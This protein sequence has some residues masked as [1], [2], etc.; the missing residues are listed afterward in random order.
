MSSTDKDPTHRTISIKVDNYTATL[1]ALTL[2][3]ALGIAAIL[4]GCPRPEQPKPEPDTTEASD[5]DG[6]G[7]DEAATV[8]ES[9]D[10]APA[11]RPDP[12]I[13]QGQLWGP[14]FPDASC[15]QPAGLTLT[16]AATIDEDGVTGAI[17]APM[18][19][20]SITCADPFLTFGQPET[21]EVI[22]QR[23]HCMIKSPCPWEGMI[24]GTGS[25]CVWPWALDRALALL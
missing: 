2:L 17:C 23:G 1:G 11:E 18:L 3:F 8:T 12:S 14:C 13:P 16:C 21:I 20:E 9:G 15:E 4:F 22:E 5:S 10:T 25:V 24:I 6:D 7:A 19:D